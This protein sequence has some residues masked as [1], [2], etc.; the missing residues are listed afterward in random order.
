MSDKV[1]IGNV[2]VVNTQYGELIKIGIKKEDFNEKCEGEWL[3]MVLKK[4]QDPSKGYYL[5][6]D[7]WK[8]A[9][10]AASS[11]QEGKQKLPF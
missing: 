7:T 2:K 9:P 8:P 10:G 11:P 6:V 4:S 5:E 3:N 1:F